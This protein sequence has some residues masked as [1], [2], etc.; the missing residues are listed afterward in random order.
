MI[1]WSNVGVETG[2]GD[3]HASWVNS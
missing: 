1:S 2:M 3:Y